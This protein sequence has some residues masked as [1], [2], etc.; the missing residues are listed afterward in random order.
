MPT[1]D[2]LRPVAPDVYTAWSGIEEGRNLSVR[3]SIRRVAAVGSTPRIRDQLQALTDALHDV[4]EA[5]PEDAFALPG[6]EEDWN[7]AETIGHDVQARVGLTLAASLAASGRWPHDAPVVVPS[8]PGPPGATRETLLSKVEQS[9]R[10]IDRA[11]VT[12][13][14]HETVPCP[15]DHPLVGRLRCGE[16]LLFAGVHDVMHLEQLYRI[17]DAFEQPARHAGAATLR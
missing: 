10:L 8:V 15:L 2:D 1:I 13:E 17:A 12:I 14:G 4:V 6:G 11:A 7:V 5:L 9:R 16:W 3:R